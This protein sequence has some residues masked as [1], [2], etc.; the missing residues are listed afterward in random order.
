MVAFRVKKGSVLQNYRRAPHRAG[1]RPV[2]R[3]ASA[4]SQRARTRTVVGTIKKPR[5]DDIIVVQS[6]AGRSE[7]PGTVW[8]VRQ[9]NRELARFRSEADA[10]NFADETAAADD[11]DVWWSDGQGIATLVAEHR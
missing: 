10:V 7:P 6:A 9:A 8:T 11:V 2:Q 4:R 5:A 3:T 1:R